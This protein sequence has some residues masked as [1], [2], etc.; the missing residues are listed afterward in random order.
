[1]IYKQSR[2]EIVL[3]QN[4]LLFLRKTRSLLKII[5]FINITNYFII[6]MLVALNFCY[7]NIYFFHK[8]VTLKN[9]VCTKGK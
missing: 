2:A 7:Y 6:N 4:S 5:T 1:M 3:L 9:K 8:F